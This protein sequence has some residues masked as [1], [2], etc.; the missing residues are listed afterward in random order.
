MRGEIKCIVGTKHEVQY[1]PLRLGRVGMGLGRKGMGL[2]RARCEAGLELWTH[3]TLWGRNKL[4]RA[5]QLTAHLCNHTHT[6]TT[7]IHYLIHLNS[8]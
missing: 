8:P 4:G 2:G 6:L 1:L 5:A 7:P 3:H